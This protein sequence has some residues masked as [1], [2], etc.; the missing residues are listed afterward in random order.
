MHLNVTDNQVYLTIQP[1]LGSF[2][3]YIVRCPEDEPWRVFSREIET[4]TCSILP[5][6]PLMNIILETIKGTFKSAVTS[7]T[8]ESMYKC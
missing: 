3:F 6:F 1:P 4:L 7:I 8:Q 2:D 5:G